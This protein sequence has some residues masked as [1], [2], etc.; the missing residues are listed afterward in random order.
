M[1]TRRAIRVVLWILLAV[2][3]ALA[4]LVAVVL[5]VPAPAERWLQA[6]MMLALR[7]HYQAN[8]QLQNLH[9][10]L[11]PTLQSYWR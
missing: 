11:V 7:E 1:T 3:V 6:R 4:I 2:F 8:V 5:I 9:V 10:T